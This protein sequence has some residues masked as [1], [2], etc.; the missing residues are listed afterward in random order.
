[1]K[2]SIVALLV[3]SA[4]WAVSPQ[5]PPT[6]DTHFLDKAMRAECTFV[7]DAKEEF[8]TLDR[9]V[10]EGL[11][12]ESTSHLIDPFNNGKYALKVVDV[13]SNALIY[14]RGFDCMFGEYTTTAPAMAGEKRAFTRSLRFPFPK[15]PVLLVIEKRDKTNLLRPLFVQRIDPSDSHIVREPA[16]LGDEVFDVIKGGDPHRKVDLVFL[17][18]GYTAQDREKFK[19]DVWRVSGWLFEVEPYKGAKEK[20]NVTGIFRP[21]SERGVDEPR[22]GAF[23][24]TALD[25]SFDA[26]GVDRYLLT[27]E[28]RT[29]RQMAA[30]A[31]YD[32]IVILVNS[33]RYGGGGIYNDYCITTVDNDRSQVVF[34]HEFGHAFAGLADEYYLSEVAYNDFY[35]KGVEP[36]EPNITADLDPSHVK[37]KDLLSPGI[38]LPTEWGKD[39]LDALDGEV[40]KTRQ[41]RQDELEAAKNK[42]LTDG[43]VKAIQ[44]KYRSKLEDLDRRIADVHKKYAG[45]EDKVGLFE[46]AGYTSKGLYRPSVFC[47]MGTSKKPLEFCRV[48]QRA[49]ARAIDDESGP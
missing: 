49:I 44:E 1:M 22:Q 26:F 25:A 4:A 15:G 41:A 3:L 19:A 6:Y 7:G 37:W 18:E 32:A 31:P 21:S 13:A 43:Q 23:K 2:T 20:F 27:E 9:I 40:Q 14:S 38:A 46:G 16:S 29:L 8:V 30:Q 39:Q 33:P 34:L 17:A 11:W 48:C 35:P 42:G 36:L 28:G 12:P 24:R 5:T 47:I 10:E 45:V